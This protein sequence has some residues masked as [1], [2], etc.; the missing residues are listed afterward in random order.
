MNQGSPG[1]PPRRWARRSV[2]RSLAVLLLWAAIFHLWGITKDL[3]YTPQVDEH[4]FVFSAARMAATGDPNPHWFGNPG[5]TVIYPLAGLFHLWNAAAHG[6]RLLR[7]DL[8]LLRAYHDHAHEFY[9]IGR[10]LCVFYGILFM[11]ET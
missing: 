2:R 1:S 10:L 6:G 7:P 4:I 8:G 11:F 5:S 3:P 9:L